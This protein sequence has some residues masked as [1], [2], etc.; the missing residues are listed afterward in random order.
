[1]EI[2]V[3]NIILVASFAFVSVAVGVKWA[4]ESLIDYQM[5]KHGM[6][7]IKE[8]NREVEDDEEF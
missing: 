3:L 8:M 1:M 2:N 6:R 4:I 5:A 7:M